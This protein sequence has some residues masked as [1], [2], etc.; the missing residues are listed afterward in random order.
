[1]R[2]GQTG[3]FR[4]LLHLLQLRGNCFR[5]YDE[6]S[7]LAK[8]EMEVVEE[9]SSDSEEVLFFNSKQQEISAENQKHRVGAFDNINEG[10]RKKN[11]VNLEPSTSTYKRFFG[12]TPQRDTFFSEFLNSIVGRK[13]D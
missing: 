12:T 1:M 7:R 13:I 6:S 4:V 2:R 5:K 3:L 10:S 11:L 8:L 9:G